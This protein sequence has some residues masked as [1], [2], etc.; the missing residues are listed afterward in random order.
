MSSVAIYMEGGGTGKGAAELRRGMNKFL[1]ELKAAARSKGWQWNLVLCGSRHEAYDT[2][3]SARDRA[4]ESEIIVLLVDAEAP[5]K[6]QTPVEHLR[7]RDGDE[8]DLTGVSAK[9]VH[10]MVQ[11]METWIV[12]DSA[13]LSAFYGPGFRANAL[14]SRQNLEEED[15][16]AVANALYVA[17]KE[18]KTKGRYHKI[19]HASQLLELIDPGKVRKRCRHCELLFST[20][21]A[22]LEAE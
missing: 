18:T 15:K 17:T 22:V 9:H 16:T 12:A 19:R 5:V 10:L 8:W 13:A 3:S 21:G 1:G 2:F 6:A 20:L 11:T 7:T 4:R 14:P